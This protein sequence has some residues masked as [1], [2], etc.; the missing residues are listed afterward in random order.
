MPEKEI[1]IHFTPQEFQLVSAL[2]LM[3]YTGMIAPIHK[4]WRPLLQQVNEK[5]QPIAIRTIIDRS[6][7][8]D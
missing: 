7:K 8:K 6:L 1:T 5:L 2:V 4:D 3:H